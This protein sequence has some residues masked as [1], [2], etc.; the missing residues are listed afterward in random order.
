VRNRPDGSVECL[1]E[2]PRPDL[3]RLLIG[4]RACPKPALVTEVKADWE[5]ARGDLGDFDVT[6]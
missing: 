1:A 3:E 2:G 4:L 6:F 5:P